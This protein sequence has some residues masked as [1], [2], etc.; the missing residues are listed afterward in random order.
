MIKYR[1]EEIAEWEKENDEL[2]RN[3]QI[4]N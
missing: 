4:W 1:E 2:G 3:V